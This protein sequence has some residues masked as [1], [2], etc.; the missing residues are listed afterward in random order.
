MSKATDVK[1]LWER[2]T[3]LRQAL[4]SEMSGGMKRL[5]AME[6]TVPQ[7]MVL[8]RLVEGPA[9]VSELQE[10]TGRSQSATSH[11]VSQLESRGLIARG[12][13]D[14]DARVTLV[15]ATAKAKKLVG[16]VEGLRLRGFATALEK[17]PPEVVKRFDAALR[18]VL[19]AIERA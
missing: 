18:Q 4:L 12:E 11:L 16:D 9:T 8:F 2:M 10:T 15:K 6:L 17:V 5:A 14:G 13:K 1:E 19:E 7:S 3:R